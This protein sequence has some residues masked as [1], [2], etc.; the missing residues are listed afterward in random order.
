M[1]PLRTIVLAEDSA[2][3]AEMTIDALTEAGLAN[4]IVHV[5]DGVE[6][7][8]YLHARGAFAGRTG[9]LPGLLLL[10]IKMSRMDGLEVLQHIRNDPAF[11]A[12]PV[13]VLSSSGEEHDLAQIGRAHV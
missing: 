1:S 10:D 6:V 13:V 11:N 8:D 9:G 4:P 5:E 3:D 7:L 2:A 12:L